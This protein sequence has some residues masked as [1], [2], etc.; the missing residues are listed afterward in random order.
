M[1]HF[2][3]PA[4]IRAQKICICKLRRHRSGGLTWEGRNEWFRTLLLDRKEG[5]REGGKEVN[6][7][8]Q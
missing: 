1:R 7:E 8:V 5:G 3:D 6:G 4:E 2:P